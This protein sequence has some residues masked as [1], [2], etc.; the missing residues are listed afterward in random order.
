MPRTSAR[1]PRRR[2]WLLTAAALSAGLGLVAAAAPAIART[3]RPDRPPVASGYTLPPPTGPERLGTVSLHLIDTARTDPWVPSH[4]TRE[5]MVQIW[6]P[7]QN[8]RGYPAAPWLSPG[9]V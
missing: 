1:P 2:R 7:A 9:A 5:I 8:T 3:D 6:Y 4:P